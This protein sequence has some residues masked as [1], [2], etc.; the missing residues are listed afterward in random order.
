VLT[1]PVIRCL[2]LQLNAEVDFLTKQN[3]QQ[4]LT[5]NQYISNI[6]SLSDNRKETIEMLRLKEYDFVVDLQNNFRSLHIRLA[7]GVKSFSYFKNN[8]Q[9]Y[10]LIYFGLNLLNKHTV[11]RYFKSVQKL[12]VFNDNKGVDYLLSSKNNLKFNTEQDY[13]CWCIGGTYEQ[14]KLSYEQILNVVSKLKISIV[15]LGGDK[16]KIISK[17]IINSTKSEN[18]YDFCGNTS[19][20]QSAYLIKNSKLVLTNDTGMMHIASA[21]YSPIISFWGC[22]K[23]SLGFAAYMP[24]HKLVNI[25]TPLSKKPCSKHGEYCRIQHNGCIKAISSE[26]IYEAILRLIK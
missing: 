15:F 24:S 22:T 9:K 26:T 1:T 7:L 14:K 13:I 11:D 2:H 5:T 17:K 16:E 12:K 4:L 19:I 10:L 3:Y 25:I 6:F 21:F 20:E 8:L 18:I 23:P